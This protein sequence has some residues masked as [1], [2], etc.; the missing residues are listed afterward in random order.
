MAYLF[1]PIAGTLRLQRGSAV[2][3]N[4]SWI[5]PHPVLP[6][7]FYA[8]NEVGEYLGAATGSIVLLYLNHSTGE[9]RVLDRASSGGA[10]PVHLSAHSSG[11]H[12]FVANY[13]GGNVQVLALDPSGV[14]RAATDLVQQGAG[15]HSSYLLPSGRFVFAPVLGLDKID[16]WSFDQ[17]TGKLAAA[18]ELQLPPNTGP[19]HM[20]FHSARPTLA[21]VADEGDGNSPCRLTVCTFDATVG[22]LSVLH[23]VST[24]PNGSSFVGVYPAEV[25]FGFDGRFAYV[26]NRDAT[27]EGRDSI[28]VFAISDDGRATLLANAPTG[29]YPRS[30]ALDPKGSFL[31]VANQKGNSLMTFAVN[32]DTGLLRANPELVVLSDSAAFV[33]FVR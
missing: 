16:Q 22:K 28:A 21:L 19:R 5:V 20:A 7:L 24:L 23:T 33:T 29:H 6:A 8:V 17:N 30:M 31:V 1:D 18:G 14:F 2:G 4:I 10:G 9:M 11:S 12:L 3:L 26:S 13:F 27:S 15:S 25:L 32:L